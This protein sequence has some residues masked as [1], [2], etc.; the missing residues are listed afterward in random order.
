MRLDPD[1]KLI[2]ES[3]RLL[4]ER[5]FAT[6]NR[7][8][9]CKALIPLGELEEAAK[10]LAKSPRFEAWIGAIELLLGEENQDET[11]GKILENLLHTMLTLDW[12]QKVEA[13]V[14]NKI[15]AKL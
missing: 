7:I 4:A 6:G 10:R 3:L 9:G 1:H 12:I 15:T 13:F 11:V 2:E 5:M 8:G 14:S